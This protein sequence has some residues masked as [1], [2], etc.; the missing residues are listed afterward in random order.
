MSKKP[1]ILFIIAD[2]FRG[3][4]WGGA[5]HPQVKTPHLDRLARGGCTFTN[6]YTPNPICVPARAV[7]ITG[8]YSHK[9]TGCKANDGTILAGSVKLPEHLAEE[10]A[11]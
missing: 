8:K 9:C 4:S 1:N 3:D 7:M 6:A 2:Q 5:H 10:K 11:V